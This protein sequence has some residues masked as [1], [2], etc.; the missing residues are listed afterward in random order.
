[1]NS[2]FFIP[3]GF[4]RKISKKGG[5]SLGGVLIKNYS[6]PIKF[7]PHNVIFHK[8]DYMKYTLCT[9]RFGIF[10]KGKTFTSWGTL[11]LALARYIDA[12]GCKYRC[13]TLGI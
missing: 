11:L 12:F 9:S 5:S 10:R 7:L 13:S 2:F 1:I 8:A 4:S 6:C 3:Q